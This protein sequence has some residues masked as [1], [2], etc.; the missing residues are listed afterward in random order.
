MA[1]IDMIIFEQFVNNFTL[2][3]QNNWIFLRVFYVGPREASSS[4]S[5]P[6]GSKYGAKQMILLLLEIGLEE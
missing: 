4:R 1:Q 6:S 5:S 3:A 2:I